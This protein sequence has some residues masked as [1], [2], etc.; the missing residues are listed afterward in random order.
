[1][2]QILIYNDEDCESTSGFGFV[3]VSFKRGDEF[4]LNYEIFLLFSTKKGVL[5]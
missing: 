1:M 4:F 2:N 5:P 3:V